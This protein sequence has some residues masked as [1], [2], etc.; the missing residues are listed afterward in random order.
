MKKSML[1]HHNENFGFKNFYISVE[2]MH[3]VIRAQTNSNCCIQIFS[4]FSSKQSEYSFKHTL[5]QQHF[6]KIIL[7]SVDRQPLVTHCSKMSASCLKINKNGILILKNRVKFS[8][9]CSKVS[10]K[11]QMNNW[12]PVLVSKQWQNDCSPNILIFFQPYL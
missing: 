12:L 11:K 7:I 4:Q 1:W 6:G 10:L 9:I 8:M 2:K 5:K 3:L